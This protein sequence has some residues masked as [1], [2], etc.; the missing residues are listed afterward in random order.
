TD[1]HLSYHGLVGGVDH[2]EHVASGVR[3]ELVGDEVTARRQVC[4]LDERNAAAS[5]NMDKRGLNR[6]SHAL[7]VALVFMVAHSPRG[8]PRVSGANITETTAPVK[9]TTAPTIMVPPVP[10][11]DREMGTRYVPMAAPMRLSEDASPTA[12]PRISVGNN[13]FG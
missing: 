11:C 9:V 1:R 6:L 3:G 10:R 7:T 8:S 13:S 2:I 12:D 4:R 5:P